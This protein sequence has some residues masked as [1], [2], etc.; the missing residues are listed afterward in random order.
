MASNDSMSESLISMV[1]AMAETNQT[2]PDSARQDFNQITQMSRDLVF[3]RTRA[4]V[5]GR[6]C[7][8]F[9]CDGIT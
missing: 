5:V 2:L 3:P 6:L 8:T 9:A 4:G 1:S 7:A